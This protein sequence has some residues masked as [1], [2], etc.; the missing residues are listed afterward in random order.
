MNWLDRLERR[1]GSFY[2]PNLMGGIVL[3]QGVIW[4][5]QMLMHNTWIGRLFSLNFS[6]VMHGQVW[7]LFTFILL[8]GSYT[9]PIFMV[10]SL[11][12]YYVIGTALERQ[13]GGFRFNLYYLVGMVGAWLAAALVGS[14]SSSGILLS[15]FFAFAWLY[16]NMEV[17]ILFIIPIKV[18]WLGLFSAVLWALDFITAPGIYKLC[19]VFQISAFL[20]F[21][22]RDVWEEI[23]RWFNNR[24]RRNNWNNNYRGY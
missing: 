6:A 22:G 13:W 16:P 1:F 19:M 8:P 12:F 15:L 17:L 18:K 24:G 21:F 4:V 10:I 14:W 7:R 11:Y 5:L 23:S 2:I 9:R 20:V 3:L